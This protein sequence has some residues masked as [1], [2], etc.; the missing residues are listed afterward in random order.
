M[1]HADCSALIA[2]SAACGPSTVK[3]DSSAR[4]QKSAGK[5]VARCGNVN[6][7]KANCVSHLTL[8]SFACLR[9]CVKSFLKTEFGS[10]QNAKSQ[11]KSRKAGH[12]QSELS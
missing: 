9:L 1:P 10:R 7:F 2:R 5:I 8:Q 11:K 12:Y 4:I 6:I 3:L